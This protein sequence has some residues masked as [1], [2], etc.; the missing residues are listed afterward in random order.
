MELHGDFIDS[1]R[2]DRIIQEDFP[3][4]DGEPFLLQKL[5]NVAVGHR[6]VKHLVLAHFP[7]GS[8]RQLRQPGGKGLGLLLVARFLNLPHPALLLDPLQVRIGRL[9]GQLLGQQEIAG[10]AVGNLQHLASP[11]QFLNVFPQ[12][13]SHEDSVNP[14]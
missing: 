13:N 1:Q 11:P 3:L 12:N 8:Q 14:P 9:E 5:R 7:H 10:V 2:L 4:V 6:A